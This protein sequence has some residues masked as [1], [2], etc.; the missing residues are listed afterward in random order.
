M[1]MSS[2]KLARVVQGPH[3]VRSNKPAREV[4]GLHTSEG[5]LWTTLSNITTSPSG[6][7]RIGTRAYALECRHDSPRRTE[8]PP[9]ARG[10][11]CTCAGARTRSLCTHK[12]AVPGRPPKWLARPWNRRPRVPAHVGSR[13][14]EPPYPDAR[15]AARASP[16][17]PTQGAA[18]SF[19]HACRT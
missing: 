4:Q 1:V 11:P 16:D 7:E 2:S 6:S 12:T 19:A 8:C 18:P 10:G 15:Q 3:D 14:R 9:R 13:T 5:G 17:P